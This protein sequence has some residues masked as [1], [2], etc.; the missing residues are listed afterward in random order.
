MQICNVESS[1]DSQSDD[2]SE[3]F[4]VPLSGTGF[5]RVGQENKSV[6]LRNKHLFVSQVDGSLL[7]N[8]DTE[9]LL[10]RKFGELPNMLNELDSLHEYDRVNGFLSAA[11][12]IYAASDAQ[13]S[14]YEE[15]Q[16]IFS[17]P[18]LMDSS[19]LADS[20]EDLLGMLFW[21]NLL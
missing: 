19:L 3:H 10:G 18:L 6:P 17:P 7:E 15:T 16:D 11:S 8:H 4:F 13:R 2:S 20:Y 12:P 21:P 9:D 14:F 1:R 5:S